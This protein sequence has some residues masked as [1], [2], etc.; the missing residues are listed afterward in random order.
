MINLT[1]WNENYHEKHDKAVMELYPDGIHGRLAQA[2][3]APDLNIRTATLDQPSCGLPDDVLAS[4]D[5]L[6]WW[7]HCRHEL[8][9]DE[10]A[11][12]VAARVNAGMG[13]IALHSAHGSK[14]F[15]KLMGTDCTLR[16]RNDDEPARLWNVAPSHPITQ[17]VPLHFELESE[18]MYGEYFSIPTPDELL[19]VTW[20]KGGEIFRGGVTFTRGMGK[21]FYFHPGHESCPSYYNENVLR[22]I[23]NAV[24]W[25]APVEKRAFGA[26]EYAEPPEKI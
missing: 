14:P 10:L 1:I 2:L 25:A 22:A 3:A 4:T 16:W 24:R 19:F 9:P 15:G 12:K 17:G 8:V 5:V 18:E 26:G 11:A 6:I 21:I 13:F 20:F 23:S 7:A